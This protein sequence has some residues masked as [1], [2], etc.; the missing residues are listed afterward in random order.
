MDKTICSNLMV[1]GWFPLC[2]KE[3][4]QMA[5]IWTIQGPRDKTPE[6]RRIRAYRGSNQ[7]QGFYFAAR[8]LA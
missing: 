6:T 8:V 7:A 3:R 2:V 1:T 5:N 4:F